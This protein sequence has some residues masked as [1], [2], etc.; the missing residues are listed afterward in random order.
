M[1]SP[2][3]NT[4]TGMQAAGQQF[5]ATYDEVTGHMNSLRGELQALR[6]RWDGS[7]ARVFEDTMTQWGVEFDKIVR[8]L[9]SMAD[10]LIGGA[11]HVEAAEDFAIQQGSFFK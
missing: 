9:D 1:T 3:S 2:T 6:S 11:G 5:I 4:S 7:A 8:D 10:R